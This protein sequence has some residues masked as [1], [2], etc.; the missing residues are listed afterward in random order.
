METRYIKSEINSTINVIR[1][2]RTDVL[3]SFNR[4]MGEE[5]Y[6]VLE[7]ASGNPDVRSILLT[8]SANAFS[9]GQDLN[10]VIDKDGLPVNPARIVTSIYNPLVKLIRSIEK[11]IVCSVNGVAAGAGANLALACDVV[12]ASTE[13]VFIQAFS[14]IGLIPDTGGTFFLPRLVGMQRASAL[15]MLGEKVTAQDALQMGMV[16]K[17]FPPNQL[18]E[19][20]ISLAKTLAEMPTKSIGYIKKALNASLS[21]D[22]DSQL[23]VEAIF[24]E[25]SGNTLDYIEGIK[26]F[27]EKRKPKFLGK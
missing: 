5:L 26:A 14:K 15:M 10:E 17:I 27:F 1:L 2:T 22:L 11:P 3:N 20:A 8:G 12:V 6:Q 9:A 13:A 23:K 24:Q 4:Q 7:S 19:S 16:Y 18:F 25:E 21:N